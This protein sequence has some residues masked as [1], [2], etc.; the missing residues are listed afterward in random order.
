MCL[1]CRPGPHLGAC[2]RQLIDVSS[3]TSMF[4]SLFFPSL[5]IFL[6]VNKI[7][8][9]DKEEGDLQVKYYF[10]GSGH[11]WAPPEV[12]WRSPMQMWRH[13]GHTWWVRHRGKQDYSSSSGHFLRAPRNNG[14]SSI[15]QGSPASGLPATQREM[16]LNVMPACM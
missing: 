12:P 6:K 5:P 10:L 11:F 1:G 16:S 8:K 9:K 4:L 14:G 13:E 3:C 7:F 15:R 2:V